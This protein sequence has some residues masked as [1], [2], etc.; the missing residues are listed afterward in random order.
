MRRSFRE[1]TAQF[2]GFLQAMYSTLSIIICFGIAYNSARISLA[3]RMHELAT[4]RVLGFTHREVATV[5]IG[6]FA[7]LTAIAIPL[8]LLMGA[9]LSVGLFSTIQNESIRLPLILTP[10]NFTFAALVTLTATS[11]SLY[12]ATRKLTQIDMVTALKARD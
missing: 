10:F 4:L 2:I 3:E 6:E 9:G 5:L 12:L 1:T 7:L 11:L 8:G